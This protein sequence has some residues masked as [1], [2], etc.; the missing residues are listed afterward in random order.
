MMI[1]NSIEPQFSFFLPLS[2]Y[3]TLT[4][5][6]QSTRLSPH[7]ITFC[8]FNQPT[9]FKPVDLHCINF[10]PDTAEVRSVL[11]EHPHKGDRPVDDF[12]RKNASTF[13]G[14][15]GTI[16]YHDQLLSLAALISS[17]GG[18]PDLLSRIG[19]D[20]VA[21]KVFAEI[22]LA[23]GGQPLD[24]EDAKPLNRSDRAVDIICDHIINNVGTPLTN[25]RMEK[26]VGLS[27]RAIS[28][29]FHLRFSCSPQEWQRAF[30]LD[31]ARKRLVSSNTLTSIKGLSC[32]LGFSSS[33][34][35]AA[36]YR[37]RFGELPSATVRI[38]SVPRRTPS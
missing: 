37:K 27:G 26:L 16:N 17:C 22:L 15:F 10:R 28:Y 36:H 31:E 14:R 9:T 24:Q 30:L 11:S 33:G 2:G 38:P 4:E 25:S 5:R 18:N 34:S 6:A 7:H 23:L 8:A 1:K 32:D 13:T 19:F 3:A 21:T 35:F 20:E 12:L 29:A